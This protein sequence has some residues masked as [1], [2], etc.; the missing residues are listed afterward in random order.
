[1]K[2]LLIVFALLLPCIAEAVEIRSY[3]VR[4]ATSADGS[5]HGTARLVLTGVQ[6]G[7]ILIPLGFPDAGS[8]RLTSAPA[9]TTLKFERGNQQTVARVAFAPFFAGAAEIAFDFDVKSAF[10]MPS[11]APG[12]KSTLPDGARMF[13]HTLVNTQ[14]AAVAAY[15]AV[16]T[17]PGGLRAHAIREALPKP[18]K[19]EAEPRVRLVDIGGRN[20][21]LLRGGRLE[22]GQSTSMQIELVKSSHSAGW[23]IA[24]ALLSILYLFQ[25]KDLVRRPDAGE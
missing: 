6:P 11:R 2:R 10:T 22:Q 15:R 24:G 7:E 25:F 12:E 20:G 18:G 3:D 4:L 16:V 19:K 21:A 14:P 1:M 17:F 5:A 23:L 13:R 9:G 8:V